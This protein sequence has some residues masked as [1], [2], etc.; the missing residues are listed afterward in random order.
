MTD[1]PSVV[2]DKSGMPPGSLVHIG[3]I[4]DVIT[5]VSV[6]D[7][8]SDSIDEARIDSIEDLVKYKNSKTITWVTVEGLTNIDVIEHI[9]KAFGVH[10]LVL[11]DILNTH[12]RPKF[13]DYDDYL[14]IVIKCLVS[15]HE[16]FELAHEQISI[17]MF[18]NLVFLFKEKKDELFYPVHKRLRASRG[19]FRSLGTD[20]L[21]YTLLDT[22]VDQN[23][24]LIDS[25]DEAISAI[26]ARLLSHESGQEVLSDIQR[27]SR[28]V[29]HVRRFVSPVRELMSEMLRSEAGLIQEQ[30]RIYLR[31]IADHA[32]RVIELVESYRE[33][34]TG[35][36]DI[37][38]TS[39]SNR[40]NDVMKVLTVFASIFIPLT[41]ITGIYGMNFEFMPE[42]K[43]R[44]AYPVLWAI[45]IVIPALLLIYF[46]RKK[47]L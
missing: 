47:W 24:V 17:L 37:Y 18:K 36:L 14:F 45:F 41:F 8:S 2:S 23:F 43:L 31:D 4:H 16:K 3:D 25:L 34:L 21:T 20:F 40:T 7:Y 6:I 19:R 27:L 29:V 39:V 33:L 44:W 26:E 13:E 12:Q 46:K 10:Q 22:I 42:L 35:L 28:E 5:T 15:K 1:T 32:L 11:E 30:T 38:I 9:G